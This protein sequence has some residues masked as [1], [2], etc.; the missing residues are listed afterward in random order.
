[1]RL[2]AVPPEMV[3]RAPEGFE[4]ASALLDLAAADDE[5]AL[6]QVLRP[7]PA[8]ADVTWSVSCYRIGDLTPSELRDFSDAVGAVRGLEGCGDPSHVAARRPV[9]AASS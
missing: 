4:A 6:R 1:M 8:R 5:A 2:A 9:S 3:G 7:D